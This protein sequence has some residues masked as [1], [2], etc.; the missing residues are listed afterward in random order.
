MVIDLNS[1]PQM[2][3]SV[4]A[5]SSMSEA[6]IASA[7]VRAL[8]PSNCQAWPPTA[9]IQWMW[10]TGTGG[11]GRAMTSPFYP[12]GVRCGQ[13]PPPPAAKISRTYASSCSR[14]PA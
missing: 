5:G 12:P 2:T 3:M 14:W 8:S 6:R 4:T 11:S 10:Q 7:S 13:P 9:S 1:R